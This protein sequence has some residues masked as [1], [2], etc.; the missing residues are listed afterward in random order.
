MGLSVCYRNNPFSSY[1][2]K[3]ELELICSSSMKISLHWF[4]DA[5]KSSFWQEVP[6][7]KIKSHHQK[8]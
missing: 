3:G 4:P 1:F 8:F 5:L 2:P 7:A 6:N